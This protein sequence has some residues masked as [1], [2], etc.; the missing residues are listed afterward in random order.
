MLIL[1]PGTTV[2]NSWTAAACARSTLCAQLY[3]CLCNQTDHPAFMDAVLQAV[4]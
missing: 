4:P 3:A 2:L 1:P